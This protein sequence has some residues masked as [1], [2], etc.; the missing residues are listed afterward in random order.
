[1]IWLPYKVT[2]DKDEKSKNFRYI[3]YHDWQLLNG[4]KLPKALNWYKLG[5]GH[6]SKKRNTLKF[7]E[8]EVR[9][10]ALKQLLF[11]PK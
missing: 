4:L 6:P 5:D 3:Q 9:P 7:I 2:F 1:M 10:E 8:V 11:Q